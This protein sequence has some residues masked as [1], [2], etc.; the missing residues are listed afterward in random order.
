MEY[1]HVVFIPDIHWPYEDKAAEKAVMSYIRKV[2]PDRTIQLGDASDFESLSRFR[3]N[4]PPSKQRH[5]KEEISYARARWE[6]WSELPTQLQWIAGNHEERLRRYAE[7]GAPELFELFDEDFDYPTLMGFDRLGIGVLG[8]RYGDGAWVGTKGGLW[9]THGDY[10]R[11]HSGTSPRA[12]VEVFGASVIHGHTHRLGEYY[13]SKIH[14]S[15]LHGIEC[16]T[17]A[18]RWQVPRGSHVVDWQTGFAEGWFARKSPRFQVDTVAI[19]DGKFVRG[20]V[21]YG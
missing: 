1:E 3:K 11:K 19:V 8:R 16:G 18:D 12:H 17:L 2:K 13:H 20:G 15:P 6:E 7:D 21:E 14:D 10:A 5:L 4:L 9:V